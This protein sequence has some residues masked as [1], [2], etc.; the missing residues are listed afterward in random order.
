MVYVSLHVSIKEMAHSTQVFQ[1]LK[2]LRS[3]FTCHC[4]LRRSNSSSASWLD[5]RFDLPPDVV[6]FILFFVEVKNFLR[7]AWRQTTAN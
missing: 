4:C 5:L 2:P 3:L 6:D 1:K 7:A